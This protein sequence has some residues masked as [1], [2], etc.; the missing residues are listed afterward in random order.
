MMNLP[1]IV[2]KIHHSSRGL[3]PIIETREISVVPWMYRQGAAAYGVPV[4]VNRGSDRAAERGTPGREDV[5]AG[6]RGADREIAQ[7]LFLSPRTVETHVPHIKEKL[8]CR[9][10]AD[11]ARRA[12]E[13]GPLSESLAERPS[14]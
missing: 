1:P 10:R 11:A 4:L 3:A 9:S 8:A 2:R 7:A 6:A 12:A 13:L 14:Q 5:G